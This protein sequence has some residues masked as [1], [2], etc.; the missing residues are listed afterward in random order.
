MSRTLLGEIVYHQGRLALQTSPRIWY[1]LDGSSGVAH[2]F[3]EAFGRAQ[4]CDLGKLVYRVRGVMQMEN[5]EQR[6]A[7]LDCVEYDPDK[8]D[9]GAWRSD[10]G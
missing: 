2:D 8:T 9:Y 5:D 7:R 6:A 3:R 10:R 1:P 4:R